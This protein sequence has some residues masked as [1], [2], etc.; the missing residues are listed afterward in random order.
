MIKTRWRQDSLLVQRPRVPFGNTTSMQTGRR[1]FL[2]PMSFALSI[3]TLSIS[4]R[5]ENQVIRVLL[6]VITLGLTTLSPLSLHPHEAG[7]L[8]LAW[9]PASP[10]GLAETQCWVLPPDLLIQS[11]WDGIQ[12][13][14]SSQG[15]LLVSGDHTLR[16]T[17][18]ECPKMTLYISSAK[19]TSLIWL[20]YSRRYFE[21]LECLNPRLF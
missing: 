20:S 10:R 17:V 18:T 14:A 11:A 19:M 4:A 6:S 12:E 5:P 3:S 8:R 21:F 16:T 15:M 7:L 2:P 13:F 9:A 1:L